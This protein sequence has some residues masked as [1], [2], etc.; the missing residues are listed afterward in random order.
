LA[1]AVASAAVVAA[2]AHAAAE[3]KIVAATGPPHAGRL[4]TGVVMTVPPHVKVLGLFCK[5]T[6]GGHIKRTS[7]GG[8]VY[9]GGTYIKPAIVRTFVS[10]RIIRATCAWEIPASATG[11]LISLGKPG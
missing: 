10:G 6:I 3:P 9:V 7:T 4:F 8:K 11:K 2:T 1:L 5:A